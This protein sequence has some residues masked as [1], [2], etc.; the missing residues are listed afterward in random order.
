MS[1]RG[2][3]KSKGASTLAIHLVAI[4][5]EVGNMGSIGHKER[6]YIVRRATSQRPWRRLATQ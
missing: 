6:E 3:V 1:A 2:L 4:Q 5:L